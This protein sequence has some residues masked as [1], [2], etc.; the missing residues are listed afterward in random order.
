MRCQA[1]AE[2]IESL[3]PEATPTDVARLCLLVSNLA[4]NIDQLSGDEEALQQAYREANLRLQMGV[5]QHAAV[6]QELEELAGSDPKQFD[7]EQIWVLL[8]SL[9]HI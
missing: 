8:L 1:L 7:R 6:A 3:D 9:I 2:R 5:D 4:D